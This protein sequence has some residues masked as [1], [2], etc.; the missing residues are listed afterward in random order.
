MSSAIMCCHLV[1]DSKAA[2]FY[3]EEE[4]K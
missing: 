3:E 4:L 2:G 1:I